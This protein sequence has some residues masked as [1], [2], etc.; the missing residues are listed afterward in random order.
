MLVILLLLCL[1]KIMAE[2]GA[3]ELDGSQRS[4]PA[5]S[6]EAVIVMHRGFLFCRM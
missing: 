6:G 3:V 1:L 2:P 5:V 4:G